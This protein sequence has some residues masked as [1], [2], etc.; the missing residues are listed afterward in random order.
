MSAQ[1]NLEQ[2]EAEAEMLK[3]RKYLVMVQISPDRFLALC[4]MVQAASLLPHQGV[5]AK[6]AVI[7]FFRA[8]D[9]FFP[10]ECAQIRALI[11]QGWANADEDADRRRA[12]GG[13]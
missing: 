6:E 5:E 3:E 8:A 7:K 12:E 4:G 2:L 9:T 10:P 13:Q 1:I 11:R